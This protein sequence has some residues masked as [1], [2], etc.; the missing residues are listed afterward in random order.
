MEHPR[1][2]QPWLAPFGDAYRILDL[3]SRPEDE[4]RLQSGCIEAALDLRRGDE[5]LD[6]A[7]ATGRHA[8]ELAK[9]GY[10]VT[11]LDLNKNYLAV[12]EKR[13]AQAG[14]T[15]ETVSQ[16][17]R[18]LPRLGLARFDAAVIMYSSFGYFP[19]HADNLR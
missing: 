1:G 7:C 19:D 18:E 16:D 8:V 2:G 4:A 14:T 10:R 6:I 13:A 11:G 5:V 9:R 12:A 15:I 3:D 17:M